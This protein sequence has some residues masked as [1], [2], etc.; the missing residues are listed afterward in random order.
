MG[1]NFA[2]IGFETA[3]FSWSNIVEQFENEFT[4]EF[5]TDKK[6]RKHFDQIIAIFLNCEYQGSF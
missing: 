1:E 4:R 6:V 2:K 3:S 5:S